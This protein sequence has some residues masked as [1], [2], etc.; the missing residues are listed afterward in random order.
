MTLR[1]AVAILKTIEDA[2]YIKDVQ[3]IVSALAEVECDPV[4]KRT[5]RSMAERKAGEL[6]Q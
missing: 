4:L 6:R 5:F 2:R 3:E 1:A